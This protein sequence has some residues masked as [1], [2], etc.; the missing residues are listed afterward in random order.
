MW[1]MCSMTT[2]LS[3]IEPRARAICERNLRRVCKSDTELA[4]DV[5][6]YWHCVA[7][8]LEAGFI[9]DDG[10]SVAHDVEAGL[11]AYVDWRL[12]HPDYKP[13]SSR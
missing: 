3:N 13:P 4:A 5:E 8:Q 9:D 1:H 10:Q 12:R 11:D 7:A 2:V 6:C